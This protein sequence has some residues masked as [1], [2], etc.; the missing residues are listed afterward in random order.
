MH[1]NRATIL[2]A[3]AIFGSADFAAAQQPKTYVIGFLSPASAASMEARIGRFRQGLQ[4]LGYVE[5][6]NITIEYRW[7]DGKDERLSDLAAE[8]VRLKVDVLASHGVLATQAAKRA[9]STTPIV[10]FA[11]GDAVS[12]GLVASLA[13]PGGNITGL[14]VLAPEVS[15]KRIELLREVVPRLSRLAVLWNSDNPVSKPEFKEAEAAAQSGGLQLQSVSVT[16]PKDFE[17]AFNSMKAERAQA[18]I[19]LSDAMLFGNRKQI[20]DYAAANQLPAISYTGEFAK[21]GTLMG[22][23]PD[24]QVLATRAASYIDKIL[25]GAKPGDL[26]IE[27]PAKFELV[28]NLKTAKALNLTIPKTLLTAADEVIE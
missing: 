17:R 24:L 3:L 10:C 7:A 23:G 25:K 9:S 26:P 28:I 13:R 27:Q 4:D 15:G 6:Q 1:L 8:L 21:S 12:V 16:G 14:T 11:C 2:A 5:G 22:Y 18:L 20:A 19:V